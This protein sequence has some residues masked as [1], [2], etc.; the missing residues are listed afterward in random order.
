MRILRRDFVNLE[1]FA[2]FLKCWESR[3]RVSRRDAVDTAT[4]ASSVSRVCSSGS[5]NSISDSVSENLL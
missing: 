2:V 1:M 3:R 5:S 4:P